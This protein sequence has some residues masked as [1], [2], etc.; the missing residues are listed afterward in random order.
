M[1]KHGPKP[2]APYKTLRDYVVWRYKHTPFG[3]K[4]I[5]VKLWPCQ[6]CDGAGR[7]RKE[8]DRDCVEG[9]K[10]APWYKCE[11]CGGTQCGPKYLVALAFEVIMADHRKALDEWTRV[12]RL[13]RSARKKLTP[14]ER[15]VLGI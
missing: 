15:A 2:K 4:L 8:E 5:D 11:A 1:V 3:D 12:D 9:Y 7:Y 10:M 6:A 14:E 13:I